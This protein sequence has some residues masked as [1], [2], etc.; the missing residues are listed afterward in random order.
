MNH[1]LFI[2]YLLYYFYIQVSHVN[3][4]SCVTNDKSY[5]WAKNIGIKDTSP[6]QY[7][8]TSTLL[9]RNVACVFIFCDWIIKSTIISHQMP[10]EHCTVFN[11]SVVHSLNLYRPFHSN[12]N[13]LVQIQSFIPICLYYLYHPF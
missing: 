6:I 5:I 1:L 11:Y 9:Y 4:C 13:S 7:L 3:I 8:R 10:V 12:H 2:V